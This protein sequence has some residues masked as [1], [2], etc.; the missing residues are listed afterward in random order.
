M[1]HPSLF[2]DGTG[3]ASHDR[4]NTAGCIPERG[5]EASA[6]SRKVAHERRSARTVIRKYVT[7]LRSAG[8]QTRPTRIVGSTLQAFKRYWNESVG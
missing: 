8:W 3:G 4:G 7:R 5:C 6:S 2:G 1:D